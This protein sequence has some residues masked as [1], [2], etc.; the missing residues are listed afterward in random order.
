MAD[1]DSGPRMIINQ[2]D[3]SALIVV[4]TATFCAWTFGVLIIRVASKINSRIAIGLEEIA[5]IFSSVGWHYRHPPRPYML[6]LWQILSIT[7]SSAIFAGVKY[8]L[9][10]SVSVKNRHDVAM[11]KVGF[12]IQTNFFGYR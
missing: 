5:V 2:D 11:S 9:G 3:H 1:E 10:K 4:V 12:L 8:S 7:C 6:I